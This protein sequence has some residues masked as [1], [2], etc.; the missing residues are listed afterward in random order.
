M[1]L[2]LCGQRRT[3][4]NLRIKHDDWLRGDGHGGGFAA[5]L[6]GT[7]APGNSEKHA[8]ADQSSKL[9]RDLGAEGRYSL[10]VMRVLR[11]KLEEFRGFEKLDLTFEQ[12]VTVLVGANGSGKTT[13]LDALAQL[14]AGALIGQPTSIQA[15]QREGSP[16]DSTVVT[17]DLTRG[18]QRFTLQLKAS[19]QPALVSSVPQLDVGPPP[20][21]VFIYYSVARAAVDT[22]PGSTNPGNW[23][24]SQTWNPSDKKHAMLSRHF[25]LEQFSAFFHWFREREDLENEDRR[26]NQSHRDPQLQAVRDAVQAVLPGY[27]R[28]RVRRPRFDGTNGSGVPSFVIDKGEQTL[29]FSQLSTG[30]R[31][32][33]A[34]VADIARRAA[35]AGP[36]RR[37]FEAEGVVL[38]DEID[39]HIHP[40]WQAVI[41]TRLRETFPNIQFI[42]A[43]HSAIVLSRVETRSVRILDK[44]QVFS[45]AFP[46]EGRDPN[47][48]ISEVFNAPL[49]PPEIQSEIGAISLL[50]DNENLSA[51]QVR[52]DALSKRLGEGDA[53]VTRLRSMHDLLSA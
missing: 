30:E 40:S 44:F 50:L 53:D 18:D 29:A 31:A 17:A 45:P 32:M 37:P 20:F 4:P 21:P 51:A 2:E 38:V 47:A 13:V 22:T 26:E 34:L 33:V 35:I 1:G 11:L 41:I 16:P 10:L 42:V 9:G 12:D 46:T 5:I 25:A 39:L 23:E 48:L 19:P 3:Q 52:L 14:M 6:P 15:D 49:R 7:L 36:N 24:P 43:T 28:P 27:S 8:S